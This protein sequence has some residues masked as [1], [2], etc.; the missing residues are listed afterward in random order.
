[1]LKAAATPDTRQ[2]LIK[3]RSRWATRSD[4][5]RAGEAFCPHEPDQRPPGLDTIARALTAATDT[6][7][8]SP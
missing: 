4:G 5:D 3:G 7:R 1:M 2:T 6:G 8:V